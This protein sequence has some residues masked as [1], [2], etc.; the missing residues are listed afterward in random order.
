LLL[1]VKI[2]RILM[3]KI[4]VLLLVLAVAGGVFAQEGVWTLGGNV[5]VGTEITLPDGADLSVVSGSGDWNNRGTLSIGY[6]IGNLSTSVGFEISNSGAGQEGRNGVSLSAEYNSGPFAAKAE[7]RLNRVM[8]LTTPAAYKD[9]I[10]SLWGYYNILGDLVHLEAAYVGR[11]NRWWGS[12]DTYGSGWGND[13]NGQDGFLVNAH[14]D[15]FD[16]GMLVPNLFEMKPAE[17]FVDKAFKQ[18]VVGFKFTMAPIVFAVNFKFENYGVYFGGTYTAGPV[19]VGLNFKGDMASGGKIGAGLSVDY[20]T[21]RFGAGV[22]VKYQLKQ[23]TYLGV[24]PS[25]WYTIIPNTFYFKTEMGFYFVDDIIW[26]LTPQLSWNFLQNGAKGYT[27]L[28]TAFGARYN[29]KSATDSKGEAR[30][31]IMKTNSLWIGFKWA[32]N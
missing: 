7:T 23:E 26:E 32:F 28:A 2:R 10:N 19:V 16:L 9:I 12:N 6:K 11:D 25:F 17:A 18:S 22:K 30:T 4:L 27:D 21:D 3:K 13:L 20:S 5:R 8:A 24:L 14:F 29:L 15:A 1:P 31:N